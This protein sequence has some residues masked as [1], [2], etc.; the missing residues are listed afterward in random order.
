MGLE[1][2][3]AHHGEEVRWEHR[4]DFL[5]HNWCFLFAAAE[6]KEGK[7]RKKWKWDGGGT[8]NGKKQRDY[9]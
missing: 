5:L 1:G 9:R 8:S 2:G 3:F 7:E 6:D 4:A